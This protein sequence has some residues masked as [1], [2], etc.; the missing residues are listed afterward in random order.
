[1]G[2]PPPPSTT[3]ALEP[4]PACAGWA[5]WRSGEEN[6]IEL[7]TV[8]GHHVGLPAHFHVEDQ[9]TFVLSGRRRFLIGNKVVALAAGQGSVIPAGVVHRSLPEPSGVFCLNAYVPVGGHVAAAAV[10][11]AGRLWC[12][13]GH[14]RPAE[15]A[16]AIR[17]HGQ[18]AGREIPPRGS[19]PAHAS[20]RE[21]VAEAA[22]RAGMSREGFSRTFAR[23]HGMPPHAFW[24]AARLNHARALL[25]AG[26]SIAAAA[27]EAGFVDQSHLGR[28]FRRAFGVTPGRYR[29]G[30]LRSQTCQTRG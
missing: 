22:A 17:E 11:E 23:Q 9:V 2:L 15:L 28:W 14:L 3:P 27:T 26:E 16:R 12:R 29:S 8:R 10:D 6:A 30:W 18:V 25:Q 21:T 20:R 1:M 19:V 13:T 4:E 5:Y 7:G 24:L